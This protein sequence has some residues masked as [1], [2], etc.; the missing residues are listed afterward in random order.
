MCMLS[1]ELVR[2]SAT[3]SVHVDSRSGLR[4]ASIRTYLRKPPLS[5]SVPLVYGAVAGVRVGLLPVPLSLAALRRVQP[6]L[7]QLELEIALSPK[8]SHRCARVANKMLTSA[9][10]RSKV[11]FGALQ[12]EFSS[13]QFV[14][15]SLVSEPRSDWV[16]L[17]QGAEAR[18]YS[19]QLFGK[20]TIV[21]ERFV[22]TYRLPELDKKLTHRYTHPHTHTQVHSPT[23]T[24]TLWY[25]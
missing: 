21:K 17:K 18:V 4:C 25:M 13:A 11:N 24:H 5:L 9:N 6:L 1:P 20:P 22:K 12:L 7:L 14:K 15:M 16:L 3:A 10:L 19:C 23:G 8:T 2:E